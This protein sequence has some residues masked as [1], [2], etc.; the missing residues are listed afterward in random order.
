MSK[1]PDLPDVPKLPPRVVGAEEVKFSFKGTQVGITPNELNELNNILERKEK[2]FN[3]LSDKEKETYLLQAH[4]NAN[5]KIHNSMQKKLGEIVKEK[6]D[7]FYKNIGTNVDYIKPGE[8]PASII[9]H[10]AREQ[11]KKILLLIYHQL[12]LIQ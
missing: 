5:R 6:R 1:I 8:D 11:L 2:Y 3:M 4:K 12:L 7:D 10:Q 9:R